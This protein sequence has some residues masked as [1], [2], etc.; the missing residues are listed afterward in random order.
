MPLPSEKASPNPRFLTVH[1][2]SKGGWGK[3]HKAPSHH[4]EDTRKRTGA[5]ETSK[6]SIF[7]QE[8]YTKKRGELRLSVWPL[9]NNETW[10]WEG[11]CAAGPRLDENAV[12]RKNKS[13]FEENTD[14]IISPSE[15]S[16]KKSKPETDALYLTPSSCSFG[17]GNVT[18]AQENIHPKSLP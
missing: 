7:Q 15:H 13:I 4:R 8:F 16:K 12:G 17:R 18:P 5:C 2:S 6:V 11:L 9:V 1:R 14:I 3:E 10:R